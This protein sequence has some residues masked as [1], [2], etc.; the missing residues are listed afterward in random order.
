MQNSPFVMSKI[1]AQNGLYSIIYH[2]LNFYLTAVIITRLNKYAVRRGKQQAQ[3][4][5]KAS[6]L[7]STHYMHLYKK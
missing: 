2:L 1:D 3:G 6:L 4:P 5:N 7:K